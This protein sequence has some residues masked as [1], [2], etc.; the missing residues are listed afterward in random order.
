[1]DAQLTSNNTPVRI[2]T[3]YRPTYDVNK[4]KIPVSLFYEEFST[5]LDDFVTS[6]MEI[7]ITGDLN[8]HINDSMDYEA[9]EFLDYLS[10]YSLTNLV[11]EPTH[12]HGNTLDLVIV[13]E[14]SSLIKDLRVLHKFSDHFLIHC[15]LNLDKPPSTKSTVGIKTCVR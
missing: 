7:I 15:T 8:F 2:L 10:Q 4:K 13:R 14:N 6:P 9:M 5:L 1:M 12:I 11:N 3:V